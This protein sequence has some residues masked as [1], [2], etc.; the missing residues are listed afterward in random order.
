MRSPD[1]KETAEL[2]G[3]FA[4]LASLIFVAMQLQQQEKMLSLEMR[5][6]MVSNLVAVNEQIIDH[7][8]TWVRGNTG[9]ELDATEFVIYESLLTNLNDYY[10]QLYS[11]FHELIPASEEQVLSM[12]AGFL[13]RNPG[14][15]RVWIDREQQLNADRTAVDPKETVTSDWI[16][17]IEARIAIIKSTQ[18]TDEQ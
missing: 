13:A 6:S 4:I 11:T 15:Y 12:Y 17:M 8:D 2:I 5:N 18:S 9:E 10:F 7:P 1:W 16:E 14:A 3:L